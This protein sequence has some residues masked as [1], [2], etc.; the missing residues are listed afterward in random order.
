MLLPL[1]PYLT[2]EQTTYWAGETLGFERGTTLFDGV[3]II[4]SEL[5]WI[6]PATFMIDNQ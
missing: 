5:R 6:M 2:T 4:D 3:I 1:L